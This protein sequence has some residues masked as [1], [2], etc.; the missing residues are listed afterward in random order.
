MNGECC[1]LVACSCSFYSFFVL[2]SRAYSGVTHISRRL[3]HMKRLSAVRKK[4]WLLF[5]SWRLLISC[6]RQKM[7]LRRNIAPKKAGCLAKWSKWIQNVFCAKMSS[8]TREIKREKYVT[9][10]LPVAQKSE[11]FQ[12]K[13]LLVFFSFFFSKFMH[14]LYVLN[15]GELSLQ[16][17]KN[18]SA[19]MTEHISL[20]EC[21]N[22]IVKPDCRQIMCAVEKKWRTALFK[23]FR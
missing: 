6:R 8:A 13:E 2:F 23:V 11:S 20:D 9:S 18:L 22:T 1:T 17:R 14:E 16:R 5:N 15:S 19:P 3:A 12:R 7:P 10:H 21:Q 4:P